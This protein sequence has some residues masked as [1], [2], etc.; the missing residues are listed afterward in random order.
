MHCKMHYKILYSFRLNAKISVFFIECKLQ[1]F[2]I[3]ESKEKYKNFRNIWVKQSLF[4]F[5]ENP[6]RQ[7]ATLLTN[8]T[9]E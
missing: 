6:A 5:L 1:F 2:F 3:V 8:D 9:V 4:L 7:Y